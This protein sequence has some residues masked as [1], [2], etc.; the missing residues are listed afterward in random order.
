MHFF[1]SKEENVTVC[2][3]Y[4]T[5]ISICDEWSTRIS[6]QMSLSVAEH[7]HGM[8]IVWGAFFASA[9]FS[10]TK[11]V[12]FIRD[13]YR[14]FFQINW[15]KHTVLCIFF[16]SCIL[17]KIWLKNMTFFW[18]VCEFKAFNCFQLHLHLDKVR[19]GLS[20]RCNRKF[21]FSD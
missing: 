7:H 6:T 5:H 21:T 10:K 15:Y 13:S 16:W 8:R 19:F 18:D 2:T 17:G 20:T 12:L 4:F 14:F 3:A 11:C 1:F 9:I